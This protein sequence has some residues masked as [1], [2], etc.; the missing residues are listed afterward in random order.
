MSTVSSIGSLLSPYESTPSSCIP[1]SDSSSDDFPSLSAEE[2][3]ESSLSSVTDGGLLSSL[4]G[5]SSSAA[6]SFANEIE[7]NLS[8]QT[9][10]LSA[11]YNESSALSS[12]AGALYNAAQDP[13]SLNCDDV[14]SFVDSFNSL[15]SGSGTGSGYVDSGDLSNLKESVTDNADALSAIGI[16]ANSDGTLSFDENTFQPALSSDP[17]SVASTLGSLA[18]SV[19]SS[20]QTLASNSLASYSSDLQKTIGFYAKL[21][22]YEASS[23]LLGQ[24]FD[25]K[26]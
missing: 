22:Q 17:N 14:S 24:L 25:T 3:L 23:T 10:S 11:F 12:S 4:A 20:S 6:S 26:V 19:Q 16:T 2:E 21:N 13:S 9:S 1:G 5:S 18:S 7:T 8:N 15:L